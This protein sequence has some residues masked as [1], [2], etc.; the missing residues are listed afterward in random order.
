MKKPDISKVFFFL[1]CL[2][3]VFAYGVFV[4]GRNV[5]PYSW[6]KV[7]EDAVVKVFE[8]RHTIARIRPDLYLNRARY[9][10]NGVTRNVQGETAPGLT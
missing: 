6:M 5:F 4:G 10:G 9:A 2:M 8:D 1:S 3:I 7:G